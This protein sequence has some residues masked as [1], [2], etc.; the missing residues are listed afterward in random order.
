MNIVR[1]ISSRVA[2]MYLGKIVELADRDR[3]FQVPLHPY[4]RA[5]MGAVCVPDP[6]VEPPEELLIEGEP[7][8]P[9]NPPTGCRF[10]TR[11]PIAVEKC[12]TVEPNFVEKVPGHWAACHLV[13]EES[14][15]E[16]PGGKVPVDSETT[17]DT[18]DPS[19][20]SGSRWSLERE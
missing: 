13:S 10:H 16:A 5:L 18:L 9:L 2:V 1:H 12:R 20:P 4:T 19:P 3:L 17:E 8:S 6:T 14:H 11:C 15:T 7:P